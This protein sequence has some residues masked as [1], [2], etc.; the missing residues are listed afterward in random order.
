MKFQD[1]LKRLDACQPA[2]DWV[3]NRGL[4]RA[5]HECNDG[6]RMMWLLEKH[7]ITPPAAYRKQLALIDA[8]YR[9]RRAPIDAAYRKQVATLIREFWPE[10]PE[11]IATALKRAGR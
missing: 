8:A 3:G 1:Y 5:W 4:K 6:R 11:A 9:K 10:P 2:V 7:S